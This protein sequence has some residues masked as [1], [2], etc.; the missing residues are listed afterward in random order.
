MTP[1]QLK[2]WRRSLGLSQRAAAL[3]LHTPRRTYED[4][5][6]SRRV[7]PGSIG[8]ACTAV[9][10]GLEPWGSEGV[11]RPGESARRR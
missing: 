7:P 4:W 3:A 8:L 6:A 9:A 1:E 11:M 2:S 10:A 5:E